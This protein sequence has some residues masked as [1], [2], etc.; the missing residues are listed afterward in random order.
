MSR[1]QCSMST[2]LVVATALV[3]G[4]SSVALADD[5]SMNRF[6]G[7]SYAYFN[8]MNATTA[9]D[10]HTRVLSKVL[11]RRNAAY[12]VEAAAC[13][14]GPYSRINTCLDTVG[15]DRTKTKMS[16][17][18]GSLAGAGPLEGQVI[19]ADLPR[20]AKASCLLNDDAGA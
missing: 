9:G 2:Q 6:T 13:K 19:C 16:A 8:G 4:V 14:R 20:A 10:H 7:D 12:R 15:L 17:K 11:A 1:K 5:S 18:V 3:L